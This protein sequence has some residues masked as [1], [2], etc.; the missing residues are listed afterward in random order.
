MIVVTIK[1]TKNPATDT[2]KIQ[3]TNMPRIRNSG[4]LSATNK[5][6]NSGTGWKLSE[7]VASLNGLIRSR[8][9]LSTEMKPGA[10][11]IRAFTTDAVYYFAGY[12]RRD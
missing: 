6:D 11:F 4:R 12:E 3:G 10:S 5:L 2:T 7:V 8:W 9:R 1:A